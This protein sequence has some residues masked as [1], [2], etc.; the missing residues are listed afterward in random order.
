MRYLLL[1]LA[2]PLTSC[3]ACRDACDNA[4]AT[5]ARTI[6]RVGYDLW[7]YYDPNPAT[8]APAG[9]LIRPDGEPSTNNLHELHEQ[10][11]F[12]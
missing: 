6:D 12:R 9:F 10:H 4:S 8:I 1:A 5:T 2:L 3:V 7:H 11:A